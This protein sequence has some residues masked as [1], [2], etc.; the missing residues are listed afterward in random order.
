LAH[1]PM[2]SRQRVQAALQHQE[3]DRVPLA[4]GGSAQH[5]AEE[6]YVKL[7]NHFGLQDI[8]RRTLVGFY[9]TPDYNPVLNALGTDLRYLHIRPPANFI[10]NSLLDIDSFQEFTDEWGLTHRF[11][12]GYYDLAGAPLAVNFTHE[13][14]ESYDWPNP[15]DPIRVQGLKEEA[16]DLY[17][18]TEFALALHRPVYG[19]LWE[20]ARVLLGMERALMATILEVDLLQHLF[21]KLAEVQLGFYQAA[22]EQVGPYVEFAEVAEDL[23]T[24]QGPMFSPDFYRNV[25]KPIHTQ[26]IAGIKSFAPGIK[27]LLHCDGA[28]RRFI[29]DLIEA[30]F[31]ILNPIESHLKG[32]DPAG[33]KADF[34][35]QLVFQGGVNIKEVMARG[36]A[37]D[38]RQEVRLRIEQMGPGGGY[39]LGPT[40]NLGTDIPLENILTFFQAGHELGAYPIE[41]E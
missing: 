24:N 3:P 27:I 12:T 38:I 30:G 4:L 2:T 28:I 1:Q 10:Q 26:F 19:N 17:N 22:L 13:G 23:G 29:P 40:H 31:D 41:T 25:M 9:T 15:F 33:L 21:E 34:G 11:R 7:R 36:T 39:I 5:L 32:M 18:N 6:R 37:D 20:M 14:I 35:D 16:L 8:P